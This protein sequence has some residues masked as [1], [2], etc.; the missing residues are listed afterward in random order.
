MRFLLFFFAVLAYA[1]AQTTTEQ[2]NCS[3]PSDCGEAE[4]CVHSDFIGKR[5]IFNDLFGGHKGECQLMRT[6]GQSCHISD[7][8]DV[9]NRDM[10]E[11]SC[12]CQAGLECRGETIEE[13][14][15]SVIHHNPKCQLP[16]GKTT[17][18]S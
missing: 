18:A 10:F 1:K 13:N 3:G 7:L 17:P 14:G 2:P 11:F 8:H 9:F 15:G 6:L 12:P 4:C 5:F 16:A